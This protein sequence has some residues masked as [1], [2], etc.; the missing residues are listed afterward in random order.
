MTNNAVFVHPTSYLFKDTPQFVVYKE[1]VQTSK[2]YMKGVTAISPYWCVFI[3]AR[4][5][6]R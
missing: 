5:V 2:S 4:T 1:I 6:W 3:G